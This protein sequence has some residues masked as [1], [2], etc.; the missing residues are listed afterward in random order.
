MREKR[1]GKR[2]HQ[3]EAISEGGGEEGVNEG[4]TSK[5]SAGSIG[6]RGDRE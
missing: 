2:K 5:C 6:A 1:R 4:R 3:G